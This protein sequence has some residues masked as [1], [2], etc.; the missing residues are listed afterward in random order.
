MTLVITELG[1]HN[2]LEGLV[3]YLPFN[4]YLVFNSV[5]RRGLKGG[6]ATRR[7]EECAEFHE[8][9]LEGR[10]SSLKNMGI[11]LTPISAQKV[12]LA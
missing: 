10:Q 7:R 3:P 12:Y 2:L 8:G 6:S 4:K 9:D 5:T 1:L 11:S